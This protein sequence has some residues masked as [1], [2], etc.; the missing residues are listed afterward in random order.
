VEPADVGGVV[1]I[2]DGRSDANSV[3]DDDQAAKGLPLR[4]RYGC[5]DS[6][7]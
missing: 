2:A 1:A 4:P 5:V 3:T 6:T 7:I